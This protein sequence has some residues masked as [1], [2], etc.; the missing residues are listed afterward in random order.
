MGF[1]V[2]FTSP[3]SFRSVSYFTLRVPV[4]G[5]GISGALLPPAA[6]S[7]AA[8]FSGMPR[9]HP[10]KAARPSQQ[11][12]GLNGAV[13]LFF[14]SLV[15]TDVQIFVKWSFCVGG[16]WMFLLFIKG[17]TQS[18][19]I[20]DE[21]FK[22]LSIP[23]VFQIPAEVRSFGQVFGSKYHQKQGVWKPSV[24]KKS[25]NRMYLGMHLWFRLA[26]TA[27]RIRGDVYSN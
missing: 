9:I 17:R 2:F 22:L 3:R 16:G 5:W 15:L 27:A 8:D 26:L 11:V 7:N 23:L 13:S 14:T 10:S 1:T 6:T 20:W 25:T 12:D 21:T 24:L 4:T 19:I 18:W